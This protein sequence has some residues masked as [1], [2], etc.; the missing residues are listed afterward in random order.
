MR[1]KVSYKNGFKKDIECITIELS[2]EQHVKFIPKQETIEVD[3]KEV[4]NEYVDVQIY[5]E[6]VSYDEVFRADRYVITD[7]IKVLQ[8]LKSQIKTN[9]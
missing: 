9:E 2:E 1:T 4:V 5:D 6:Q 8:E 7:I 3:G